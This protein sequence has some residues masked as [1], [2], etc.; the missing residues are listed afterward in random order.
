MVTEYDSYIES[1]LFVSNFIFQF[2]T[3][4][5]LQLA[6]ERSF[7]TGLFLGN[8][9]LFLSST[10]TLYEQLGVKLVKIA[11]F[12]R[13]QQLTL[14]TLISDD[15][16]SLYQDILSMGSGF[17]LSAEWYRTSI[18]APLKSIFLTNRTERDAAVKRYRK[19]RQESVEARKLAL[20]NYSRTTSATKTAEA[21]IEAWFSKLQQNR[22]P[23]K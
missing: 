23:R 6:V 11:Q 8:V 7:T 9:S 22:T 5:G 18:I 19:L 13:P 21:E 2:S 16:Q 1:I 4:L 3:W 20:A 17:R 14:E 12:V 10:T 15:F